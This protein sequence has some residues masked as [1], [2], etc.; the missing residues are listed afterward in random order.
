MARKLPSLGEALVKE[1]ETAWKQPQED[2]ARTRLLVVRLIA[3]HEMT[4]AQIMQVADVSRQT[5]FT[6]RDKLVA[7]GVAGLLKRDWSGARVPVVRGAVAQEFIKRLEAGQFRQARDAQRWIKK[8]TRQTLSESGVRKI[9]HRLGGK[10]KVPRKSHAKKDP[11][12]AAKFKEELPA[13]LTEVVGPAPMQP[14]RLWVLDEHRYGLLPVIRRVWARR[15]VRVHAPYATR[16]KWGYLH[17]ALE[18]DGEHSSQL[19][20]TPAIDRDIHALFLK[21]IAD[22]DPQSLHVVIADQAGFHLPVADP[23]IPANVR[24]LPLPPYSPELNPVE[25]FGGLIK[26]AIGNRLYP[27]LYKLENH[28]SAVARTWTQPAKVAGLIHSWLL[29]QANGGVLT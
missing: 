29:D 14:V 18:V 22:A 19:L 1:I 9:L 11:A 15:G 21:Q 2:W 17:E 26:A 6:Y 12:K 24:L 7:Q 20:F 10:L 5:V 16:Y 23:R 3:Q 28:I 25:R 13:K 8:R 27:N 4:V